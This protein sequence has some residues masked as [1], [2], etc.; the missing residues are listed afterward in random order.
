ML[1]LALDQVTK[2]LALEQ[3]GHRTIELWW[4]LQLNLH[5]ND[6]GA[7]GFGRGMAPLFIAAGVTLLAVLLFVSRSVTGPAM[8]VALGMIVGGAIGNLVDRL[9]RDHNGAVIDFIDFQWWPIF[10]VADMAIT[11][12]AALLLLTGGRRPHER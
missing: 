3:L 10:N 2:T 7:F 6:G 11:C 5:F 9:L 4:T 8:A 1:V 12:G